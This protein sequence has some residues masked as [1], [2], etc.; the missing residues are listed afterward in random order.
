MQPSQGLKVE[1][2]QAIRVLVP[3]RKR[4]TRFELIVDKGGL[5]DSLL[6]PGPFGPTGMPR[7]VRSD[8]M[9][10]GSAA[11]H[12][13]AFRGA[14]RCRDHLWLNLHALYWLG[15]SPDRLVEIYKTYAPAR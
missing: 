10:Q 3:M 14:A 4:F 12:F 9:H 5:R 6:G 8:E 15:L 13:A 11:D 7:T 2:H 1:S